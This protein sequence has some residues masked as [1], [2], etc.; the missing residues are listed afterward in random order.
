MAERRRR[1]DATLPHRR[2][3]RRL[4]G[5]L[6]T[7]LVVALVVAVVLVAGWLV[8]FSSY[9]SAE[10]VRVTGE[11]SVA[12]ARV[13]HV[14]RVP[15]GTPL[16]RVDTDAVRARVE[17]I[18]SVDSV[19]V[20]RS[21]P[22]TIDITITERTPVALVETDNGRRAVDAGGV[23]FPVPPHHA[24]LPLIRAGAATDTV[25]LREAARVAGA[26][27]ADIAHKVDHLEL[28]SAD[29]I[30]LVLR[31]GRTIVWGS[32]ADSEVKARVVA[33]LLR[34]KVRQVDVSVPGRPTTR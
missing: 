14:A 1:V 5:R 25:S 29:D 2:L 18:S 15:L 32:A 9:L 26:V 34:G 28:R 3:R 4:R 13:R 11:V 20:S 23:L 12:P 31:D 22:H 21:W 6:R 8:L 7:V 27:P 30:R 17:T 10:Q 33:L 16:A 19:Q 24:R